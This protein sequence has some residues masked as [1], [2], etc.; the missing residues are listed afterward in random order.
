MHAYVVPCV[1]VCEFV[2]VFVHQC[3]NVLLHIYTYYILYIVCT[4]TCSY[5]YM[6]SAECCIVIGTHVSLQGSW[7]YVLLFIVY[8]V[9][10]LTC[11]ERFLLGQSRII[12]HNDVIDASLEKSSGQTLLLT[13]GSSCSGH[14]H[15]YTVNNRLTILSLTTPPCSCYKTKRRETYRESNI[16][17]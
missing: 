17:Q 10:S 14:E 5:M 3:I 1:G 2:C 11:L 16:S 15:T 6:N 13:E 9:K 8:S 4:G 7:E 12:G